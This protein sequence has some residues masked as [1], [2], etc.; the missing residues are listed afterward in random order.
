VRNHRRLTQDNDA[1]PPSIDQE[2]FWPRG[3]Q[4]ATVGIFVIAAIWSGYVA[5]PVVLPVLLGWVVAT[6]ILPIVKRIQSWGVPRVIADQC[7]LL[8]SL[9]VPPVKKSGS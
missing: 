5:Q 7:D 2:D 4:V 9:Q 3:S 8:E 6:I 1:E